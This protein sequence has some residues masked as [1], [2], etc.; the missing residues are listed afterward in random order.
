MPTAPCCGCARLN[1]AFGRRAILHDIALSVRAGEFAVIVGPNG[2]GKTTLL[3]AAAGLVPAE[4]DLIV[5]GDDVRHLSPAE[6][7]RRIAYL[8][9]GQEF[10]WPLAVRDVVG[11]GRLPRGAGASLSAADH[12]AVRA[13]MAATGVT[14]YAERAVTT[15]S[16]GERARV[17]IARVLATEAPVI[18]ADEPTAALDP[19]YQ[20]I[21][22][23]ILRR[24][25]EAGGAVLA[26]LH[27]I[28]LAARRATRV[29]VLDGGRIVADGLPRD[30]L[31]RERLAETFGVTAE[32][33][34]LDGAPVVIP[35]SVTERQ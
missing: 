34:E 33:M 1:V 27:D 30:V 26:A 12:E 23:D 18:L 4:G 2:A 28:G 3:R 7:A 14:D 25:A 13:A 21:V 10:Y 24:R 17:A 16:G 35:W 11:L 20:L 31:T 6:R 19:R 8:P 5:G 22:L 29:I 9:Q 32:I 15:L